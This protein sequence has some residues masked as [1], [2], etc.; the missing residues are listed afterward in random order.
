MTFA[1]V[2]AK[3]TFTGFSAADQATILGAMQTAYNGS[4]TAKAMFDSYIATPSNTINVQFQAGAFAASAGTG[5]LFLDLSFLTN[6]TYITPTGQAVEDTALSGIVHELG[7]ALTGRLDN[8]NTVDYKGD[9]VTFVNT[10]FTELGLPEQVSY[11]AYDVDG[12]LHELNYNYTNGAT[13]DRAFSGDSNW[14]S[15]PAGNS[16]DLL[17]GGASAN[18]LQSGAGDDFI[19]GAGGDDNLN[20]GDGTGDTVIFRGNP[21][22]YD[23]RQN[24]DGT[25]TSRHVRGA[26]NEG[27]D[28]LTNFE[29]VLFQSGQA[30][31]L[32]KEG[33]TYQTDFALVIDTTGSMGDDI[34]AVKAQGNAI[35]NALF[36]G[37]TK[38][39]RFGIVGFKDTTNGEPTS[40][41]LPFTDQ[42]QFADR[43][44]AAIAALNGI[45]VDGGGDTPET[46]FDGLLKALD[47]TMGNWRTGA[48]IHR[49]AL[50]TDAPA[51][52]SELSGA[53][54][55]LAANIGATISSRAQ[56]VGARGSLN[57]F[58]LNLKAGT[59]L[60]GRDLSSEPDTGPLPPFVPTDDPQV[61]D[62]TTASLE[63][64][65]INTNAFD[66]L[67]PDLAAIAS[68]TGGSSFTAPDPEDLAEVL[69]EI[70]ELPDNSPPVAQDD[71]FTTNQDI[72]LTGS[73]FANNGSGADSDADGDPLTVTAVN[74]N[75]E[76][77]VE[78]GTE[79]V[80]ASGATLTVQSDGA[81]SYDPAGNG[82]I[83]D[84]FTYTVSDGQE[85]T[86]EGVVT[87]AVGITA[88]FGNGQDNEIG[89]AG[90]DIL[91][92]GLGA[93][94]LNGV[95]GNDTLS[96]DAGNDKLL[97]GSGKDALSGLEGNDSL[98]GDAGDD[99]LSG[100]AGDDS[101]FGGTGSAERG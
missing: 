32:K 65:T 56:S 64:Y 59:Q 43:K 94:T 81:F 67:D 74:V 5:S 28:T 17:I 51:K 7:H 15:S 100:G 46:A 63:I 8:W 72:A 73:V 62:T 68:E 86:D 20:A 1:D 35:I 55:A 36:A 30:F 47:G 37:D 34:D 52:D 95:G 23:L 33:L 96:G 40:V 11:I 44:S 78:I 3:T 84:S 83:I 21:T 82:D 29:K 45:S 48:G 75:G 26:A 69:I 22:D 53:V 85:G 99:S 38:D 16:K 14:N 97:G 93:D 77:S 31:D 80:L 10:I 54:A 89:T 98:L 60:V 50:F 76:E 27:T 57:T 19:F 12:S 91:A 101:L 4:A 87:I 9:N 49:V 42:D 92:G 88:N 90:N 13:I 2:Q 25:W 61:P 41:I 71:T 79:T 70:I 24:P 6:N 39:A 58:E 66:V 18:N